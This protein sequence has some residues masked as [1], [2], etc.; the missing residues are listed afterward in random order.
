MLT[1]CL[2]SQYYIIFCVQYHVLCVFVR[3]GGGLTVFFAHLG[4]STDGCAS[5]KF[6]HLWGEGRFWFWDICWFFC[7][8]RGAT[9]WVVVERL[10]VALVPMCACRV[11]L[12]L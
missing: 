10:V 1:C 11:W 6:D 8:I 9:S 7:G 12:D 4:V 3:A 2:D 5:C